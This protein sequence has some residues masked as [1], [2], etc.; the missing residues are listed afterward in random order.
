MAPN[1]YIGNYK[2]FTG[3]YAY[4]DQII[5]ALEACVEDGMD[6]INMSLGDEVYIET[7]L[8]PEA[9]AVRN[10]IASGVIVVAAAGNSGTTESIGSPG[11][12]PEVITVGSVSNASYRRSGPSN[13]LG[14]K[15]N[16]YIDG[17]LVLEEVAITTGEDADYYS[18]LSHWPF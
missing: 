11:L 15:M 14:A 9:L 7:H 1:A 17:E 16:V 13:R 12:V 3:E 8:D 18:N 2:V 10:A 4:S 6:I 5:A